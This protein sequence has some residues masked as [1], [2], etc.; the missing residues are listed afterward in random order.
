L[1]PIF[2]NPDVPKRHRLFY[3]GMGFEIPYEI[4]SLE[5]CCA[6]RMA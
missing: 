4:I 3:A 6:L 2:V 5:A 1:Q